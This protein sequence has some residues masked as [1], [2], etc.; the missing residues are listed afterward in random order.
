MEVACV[1]GAGGGQQSPPQSAPPRAHLRAV[2]GDGRAFA[3]PLR[4]VVADDSLAVRT[5]LVALLSAEPDFVVAGEAE[6]GTAALRV[7]AA[8]PV[9]LLLLD[10]SMP[11]LDGLEVLE[12]LRESHPKPRV[13][14]YS[15]HSARSV[16][17]RAEELGAADFILKGTEP[18]E[19]L[20]RLRRIG[21]GR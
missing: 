7:V 16:R 19:L 13:V 2:E 8:A 9:D 1:A 4:I 20:E 3:A 6:T 14:I 18:E 21:R 12:R 17:R 11:E 15:G 5:M 10:L